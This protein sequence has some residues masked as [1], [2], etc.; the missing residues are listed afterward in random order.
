M[1][2]IKILALSFCFVFAVSS[3]IAK[4]KKLHTVGDMIGEALTSIIHCPDLEVN[5]GVLGLVIVNYGI[6][7]KGEP[8]QQAI[9][10]QREISNKFVEEFGA[11]IWCDTIDTLY[12]AHG[13]NIPRLV[14]PKKGDR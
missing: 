6:D 10:R 9:S 8:T 4:E 2:I 5:K 13:V 14:R 12:G 1:R 11:D 3:I 7:A